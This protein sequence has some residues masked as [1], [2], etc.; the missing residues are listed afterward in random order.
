[1]KWSDYLLGMAGGCAILIHMS[2]SGSVQRHCTQHHCPGPDEGNNVDMALVLLPA[3]RNMSCRWSLTTQTLHSQVYH[4]YPTAWDSRTACIG[5]SGCLYRFMS[6]QDALTV[7]DFTKS[8]SFLSYVDP[9]YR[10]ELLPRKAQMTC[11]K[12]GKTR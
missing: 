10:P 2:C 4:C 12:G 8:T 11:H 6:T 7:K 9:G 5:T 1:M 3:L